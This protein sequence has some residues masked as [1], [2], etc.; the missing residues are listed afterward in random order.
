MKENSVGQIY[1]NLIS[2]WHPTLNGELT[3]FGVTPGMHLKVWW[4]CLKNHAHE[5]QTYIY[6][7][8]RKKDSKKCPHC[9]NQVLS[10]LNCLKNVNPELSKEWCY[11]L[12]G[13]LTL[14]D[15][16]A[17]GAQIVWWE[18]SNGHQWRAQ[19]YER[20]EGRAPCKSCT[21]LAFNNPDLLKEWNYEKN[22]S[23]NP[24]KLNFQSNKVVWWNCVK[25]G[26]EW[27]ASIS[28]R[29]KGNKWCKRC[30]SISVTH[31]DIVK[32]WHLTKNPGLSPE[33]LSFGSNKEVVWQCTRKKE[34][35]WSETVNSRCSRIFGCTQ[36]FKGTSTSLFEMI[37]YLS[38]LEGIPSIKHREKYN[39]Y[40]ADIL[41]RNVKFALEFD[42]Y[43]YHKD[44]LS[45]DKEKNQAFKKLKFIRVRECPLE[46][47]KDFECLNIQLVCRRKLETYI[48]CYKLIITQ[49]ENWFPQSKF[50]DFDA[51]WRVNIEEKRMEALILLNSVPREES[52]GEKYLSLV[53]EWDYK[54]N[55]DL[56]PW[57]VRPFSNEKVNW[58]CKKETCKHRWSATP[59]K[60]SDGRGCPKCKGRGSAMV[61]DNSNSLYSL[62]PLVSKELHPNL[63]KE[64]TPETI[65]AYSTKEFWWNCPVR[66]EQ[67][68]WQESVEGR[69]G[70]DIGCPFCNEEN[71]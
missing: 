35:V 37:L 46:D 8:A 51:L 5:W 18:C 61:I 39:K 3:I 4:R 32:E 31:P 17:G 7:R 58:I 45:L 62:F 71:E 38:L 22:A 29:V 23:I 65:Y 14:K 63:N 40:E 47:I 16:Q 1:P 59:A 27:E 52:L 2:E 30:K 69:T 13:S 49:L 66:G 54:K 42:S 28:Q 70:N 53:S 36:C 33:E 26:N 9:S 68:V 24:W 67:H 60:R 41:C 19:I 43:H 15:V 44:K 56:T 57:D 11:E 12:N 6:N 10:E 55:G 34:H 64:A 21:S 25:C 50:I 20:N 48:N